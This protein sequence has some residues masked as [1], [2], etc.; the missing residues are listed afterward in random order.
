ME[1]N[2]TEFKRELTDWLEKEVIAF[3][4]YHDGGLVY[5]GVDAVGDVFGVPDCDAVQLAIKDRLKN[6]IQ[7]SCLGL[8][9]VIH[10]TR[11]GK[12]IIKLIIASGSEK[13]WRLPRQA[14][15]TPAR[16][17]MIFSPDIPCRATKP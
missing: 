7:P 2:R 6:N 17:R 9:D 16:N 11:D 5:I 8:F 1:N 15:F 10:E 13:R 12:Y 4:N 3:L 14:S